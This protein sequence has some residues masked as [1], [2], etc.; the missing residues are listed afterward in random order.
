MPRSTT[1][2]IASVQEQIRQL[3][4]QKKRLLQEQKEQERKARTKRLIERGAML[5]SMIADAPALTNEQIKAFLEKT[6]KTDYAHRALANLNASNSAAAPQTGSGDTG[7][8]A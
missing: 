1:E 2:K 4:N 5:E 3:E 8:V 6:V 7:R